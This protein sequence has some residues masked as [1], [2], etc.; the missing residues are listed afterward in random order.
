MNRTL[1]HFRPNNQGSSSCLNGL[2][3][4]WVAVG[5]AEVE[6]VVI[7]ERE[8]VVGEVGGSMVIAGRRLASRRRFTNRR[9]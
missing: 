7:E 3:A 1:A 5:A 2:A 4:L 9:R 6:V 8:H